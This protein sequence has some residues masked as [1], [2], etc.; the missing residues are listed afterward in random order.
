M[1]DST[2]PVIIYSTEW[3]AYCKHVEGYLTDKNVPWVTKDI[4]HD[5]AAYKEVEGKMGGPVRSVP[6]IDVNG[7]MILGFDR[8]AIDAALA[9]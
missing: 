4:E 6:V 2:N 3:C 1:A 7:T 5:A 8:P 9:A